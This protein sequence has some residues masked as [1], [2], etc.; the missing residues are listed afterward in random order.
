MEKIKAWF[1]RQQDR[2]SGVFR[3]FLGTL[4]LTLVLCVFW[5][6]VEISGR[7]PGNTEEYVVIF[8]AMAIVG[9]FFTECALRGQ[10][11]KEATIT[12]YVFAGLGAF[13]WVILDVICKSDVSDITRYYMLVSAVL[14]VL[15]LLGLAFLALIKESGLSFEQYTLRIIIASLRMLAILV[16]LNLGILLILW[17]FSTLITKFDYTNWLYYTEIILFA[18]VYV[19]YG[20]SCLI[21]RTEPEQTKFA[22][23]LVLYALMPMLIA[24]MGIVYIYMIKLVVTWDFPSNQV[25]L[26]CAALFCVGFLIWT[27][28]YAYTRR[29][30]SVIYNKIIRYMKYIYAPFIL[31]ESYAI[32]VRI[33][34]HGWTIVRY[35]AVAFIVLQVVYIAWEPIANLVLL[36]CRKKKIHYAE[37]Y[38]WIIYVAFGLAFFA[39]V[40]PWSSAEYVEYASQKSRFEKVYADVQ[41]MYEM[42][43][44]WTPEEYQ[45]VAKLQYSGR[46][47][48]RVLQSNVYGEDYLTVNYV[49]NELSRVFSMDSSRMYGKGN[50]EPTDP[51]GNIDISDY[52]SGGLDE[53]KGLPIENYRRMYTTSLFLAYDTPVE[54][55]ELTHLELSY[56]D[57]NVVHVDLSDSI[58]NMIS[59]ANRTD[60]K[61]ADAGRENAGNTT[62]FATEASAE[63]IEQRERELFE[64][65]VENGV[66]L[67]TQITFRYDSQLKMVYNLSV[68]GYLLVE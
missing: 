53:T 30:V 48:Q 5:D 3:K 44:M 7:R 33:A 59:E 38:E 14:Y 49:A 10:K 57:G 34:E 55:M 61:E 62:D 29:N 19:P 39:L 35:A 13:L 6:S 32:G 22:R 45:E 16:V 8:L 17:L 12:G 23:G 41:K 60:K 51:T 15:V 66:L 31:L 36:I 67:I 4:F 54:W 37:H 40:F 42:D 56:G 11:S 47:I 65:K 46:S 52:F 26:I 58:A 25:Y 64:L 27:M 9:T 21:D 20:L 68:N 50:T 28:A 18:L 2:L 63:M 24:S 43:R 1:E